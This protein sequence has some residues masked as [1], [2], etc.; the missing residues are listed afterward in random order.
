VRNR[1]VGGLAPGF[2]VDKQGSWP[3]VAGSLTLEFNQ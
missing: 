1:K 2:T 3:S